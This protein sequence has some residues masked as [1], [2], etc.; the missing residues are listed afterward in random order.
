MALYL[1][2]IRRTDMPD[3][4][5]WQE[6]SGVLHERGTELASVLAHGERVEVYDKNLRGVASFTKWD[7]KV[8]TASLRHCRLHSKVASSSPEQN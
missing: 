3:A 8:R 5:E 6:F 1:Y 4:Y 2:R 7:S